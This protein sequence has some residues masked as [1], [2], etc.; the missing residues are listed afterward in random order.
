MSFPAPVAGL[1]IRYAFLWRNEASRG[2]EE[3]AKDR[4]CAVILVTN[5]DDGEALVT[6]LPITHT[7][8][9]DERLAVELPPATKRRLGLDDARSWIVVTDANRFIWPGPDLRPARP[10]DAASVAYG[11][12]PTGVFNEMRDKFL[13]AVRARR[14]GQVQRSA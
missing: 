2:Q 4:P 7:P 5:D 12:L 1:V 8:P 11:L 6:V 9:A 3:G 13:A 10:G 14:A